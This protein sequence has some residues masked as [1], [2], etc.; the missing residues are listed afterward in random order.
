MPIHI[1]S[2][3]PLWIHERIFR[4]NLQFLTIYCVNVWLQ[5]ETDISVLGFRVQLLEKDM[6]SA[7]ETA[8]C[9]IAGPTVTLAPADKELYKRR[10]VT[11][12]VDSIPLCVGQFIFTMY[13]FCV[14]EL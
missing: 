2:L 11:A 14:L 9:F 5:K 12:T 1:E 8:G 13:I 6:Q 4:L 7:L 3:N 10:D